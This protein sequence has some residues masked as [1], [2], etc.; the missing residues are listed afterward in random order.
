[1][2]LVDTRADLYENL[3]INRRTTIFDPEGDQLFYFLPLMPLMRSIVYGNQSFMRWNYS[4][5]PN[6]NL[7]AQNFSRVLKNATRTICSEPFYASYE[8]IKVISV[9]NSFFDF[10]SL[11][12]FFDYDD[13]IVESSFMISK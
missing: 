1:M 13:D 9:P 7:V 2:R 3:K 10:Q 8:S 12:S 11:Y 6:L 5:F 4:K